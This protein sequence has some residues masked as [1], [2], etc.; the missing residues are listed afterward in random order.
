MPSYRNKAGNKK[1]TR[2][3]DYVALQA[4]S[5]PDL[6]DFL[7]LARERFKIAVD[8][9]APWRNAAL[10][11][12]RFLTGDQWPQATKQAR[13][14]ANRPCLTINRLPAIKRQLVNE[15]RAQRP[16]I[17]VRPVGNG[18]DVDDAEMLEGLIRHIEVQSDV[19]IADDTAFEH[20]VTG[21]RGY[22]EVCSDY[23]PGATFDQEL[24]IKRVKNPFTCYCDPSSVMPDESDAEWKFEICDYPKAEYVQKFK[25]SELASLSDFM[26]I[27]DNFPQWGDSKTIRVAKYWHK[28][29]EEDVL[30]KLAN[31]DVLTKK[32]Y[33]LRHKGIEEDRKLEIIA[34]RP[35]RSCKIVCS[36]IN[37]IEELEQYIFPGKVGFIPLIP[38]IGE[39]FDVNGVRYL[40]GIIREAKDPQRSINYFR[41]YAAETIALAPKAPF[42]GWKGQFKDAKWQTANVVNYAYLEADL[43]TTEGTPAPSLPQ[44]NS[45]EPPIQAVL[46]L[47]QVIDGD[48]KAV[49]GI[50]EPSL[51]QP[52]GDQS[53]KAVDSLQ[54]QSQLTNLNFTDNLSR[55]KR[56]VGRVLLDAA[57]FIY[58]APRVQR[59]INPDGSPDMVILHS[60]RPTAANGLKTPDIQDV[61]DLSMGSYDV[62]V[63]VGPAYKTR[64]ME[65]FQQLSNL[66]AADKTGEI[67]KVSADLIIGMSDAPEAK[68]VAQRLKKAMPPNLVNDD[69]GD[70]RQ[71]LQQATATLRQLEQ[72]N[73]ELMKQNAQMIDT[74]K[75][76]QVQQNGKMEIAKIQAAAQVEVAGLN[77]KL[78]QAKLEFEKFELLHTT[79]HEQAMAAN[80]AAQEAAAAQSGNG[81]GQ[82]G[83]APP[84][85]AV[86]GAAQS[87]AGA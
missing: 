41:S 15:Q 65:A 43:M 23:L 47:S 50:Y 31:G 84:P 64:R 22:L 68:L 30:Y 82:G 63:D 40:A 71:Q 26:S 55:M 49:T 17:V 19:E 76:E 34:E 8:A 27:G 52:K 77:A 79:A 73:Q 62:V 58:D 72:Q 36:V 1:P 46:A 53:G 45:A 74:I 44:R 81:E 4:S 69:P 85:Q 51:G 13:D 11:D 42:I 70:P 12:L 37:A 56:H 80:Q 35:Y 78:E 14:Q 33:D 3:K 20:M 5:N 9:E 18:A 83:Q 7:A 66:A 6:K 39:D 38:C 32:N 86:N 54:Q 21:G 25:D 29:Y 16:Q 48:L 59:I 57:P 10:E 60:G 28:D 75:T 24:Y 87:Q 61:Y 2:I 67:F